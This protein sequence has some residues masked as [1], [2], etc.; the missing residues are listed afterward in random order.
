MK[1]RLVIE[2]FFTAAFFFSV[3]L[4]APHFSFSQSDEATSIEDEEIDA[5]E[6][7]DK[8][9]LG[10]IENISIYPGN[11]ILNAKLDTGADH[12]SLHARNIEP[13]KRKGKEWVRF[14]IE[15]RQGE[16]L[17]LE[18]ETHRIAKIKRLLGKPQE[19]YVV[20]LGLCVGNDYTEVDVNLVDRSN[21]SFPV[22]IGRNFLA[23]VIMVD[24]SATYTQEPNCVVN[25]KDTK[26]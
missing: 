21:F 13:F 3:L 15:N 26:R 23:G 2:K 19:R 17:T 14:D 16:K 18:R 1:K 10:W 20:R 12:C 11:F 24:P 4:F 22:L 25:V 9:A 5:Q 6:S 8:Q 7:L